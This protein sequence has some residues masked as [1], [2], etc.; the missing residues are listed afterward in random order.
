[1]F[2]SRMNRHSA[3]PATA[4]LS[5]KSLLLSFVTSS[6]RSISRQL[7]S[8]ADASTSHDFGRHEPGQFALE[9]IAW[10]VGPILLSLK[11]YHTQLV[12]VRGISSQQ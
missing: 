6:L 3:P 1:M 7:F 2:T 11:S 12:F 10:C 5:V 8:S 9:R 4:N